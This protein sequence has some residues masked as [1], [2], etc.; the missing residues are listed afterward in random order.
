MADS[1]P[2]AVCNLRAFVS[3][4]CSSCTASYCLDHRPL[5]EGCRGC[6]RAPAA[7]LASSSAPAA[8]QH[9]CTRCRRAVAVA[10]ACPLCRA[11]FC[12]EHRDPAAH[13]C[14]AGGGGGS[15][16]DGGGGEGGSASAGS[17]GG[18][19]GRSA[20][21][22]PLD[23]AY[24]AAATSGG[25]GAAAA[26]LRAKV[27]LTKLRMAT[28]APPG[29]AAA[30]R[31]YL[32]LRVGAA[33][34]AAAPAVPA[35]LCISRHATGA[36]LVDAAAAA[37]GVRGGGA[38]LRL[39][40]QRFAD[41]AAAAA[42]AAASAAAAAAAADANAGAY[43]AGGG[44][45]LLLPLD[46]RLSDDAALAAGGGALADGDTVILVRDES[47]PPAALLLR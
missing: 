26:A 36:R 24:V 21:I 45:A 41:T 40:V 38:G 29:I 11:V 34:Q 1:L 19:P 22:A 39:A 33:V 16:G 28:S 30:D 23:V 15:S 2:C 46:A 18:G 37:V 12:L 27:A 44:A 31:L 9:A 47:L 43:T 35:S 10:T 3:F 4:R 5:G 6:C 17:A 42:T 32:F 20:V 7:A 25:G 13:V 14:A 8:F